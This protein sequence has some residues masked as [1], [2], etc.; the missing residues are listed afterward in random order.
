MTAPSVLRVPN[1][2]RLARS[3]P[4][5]QRARLVSGPLPI[6]W[7]SVPR[8]SSER[9]F[10]PL[11]RAGQCGELLRDERAVT[12]AVLAV[13]VEGG[14]ELGVLDDADGAGAIGDDGLRGT[15]QFHTCSMARTLFVSTKVKK[16][17]VS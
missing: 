5:S 3:R 17:V 12:E 14:F 8:G 1:A 6:V 2:G 11:S 16:A 15:V 7:L 13:D 9:P 10:R 4:K